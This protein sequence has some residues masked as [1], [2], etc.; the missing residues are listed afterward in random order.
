MD[1][2]HFMS[3]LN[4][5]KASTVVQL[6]DIMRG[7]EMRSETTFDASTSEH[8]RK[9]YG[10]FELQSLPTIKIKSFHKRKSKELIDRTMAL[11]FHGFVQKG[12]H[13]RFVSVPFQIS[14]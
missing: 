9:T 3:A 2:Y 5:A 11:F 8:D 14:P 7:L 6:M 4:L 10:G 12:L 13:S 1:G